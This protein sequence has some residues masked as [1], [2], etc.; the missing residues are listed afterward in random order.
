[1]VMSEPPHAHQ[2]T[3]VGVTLPELPGAEPR[4][5]RVRCM[6]CGT[7][8]TIDEDLSLYPADYY[9]GAPAGILSHDGPA[10]SNTVTVPGARRE[11]V[12]RA[13]LV[14]KLAERFDTAH[15]F[16]DMATCCQCGWSYGSPESY[17]EHLAA[18]AVDVFFD[19]LRSL[20]A[21]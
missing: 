17:A 3:V 6:K 13:E 4:R 1:M 5:A 8:E 12:A 19:E 15:E 21:N 10:G 9:V 11:A 20:P 18:V 14:E 2:W 7:I 16:D